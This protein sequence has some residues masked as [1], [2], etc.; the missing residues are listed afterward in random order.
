MHVATSTIERLL[1]YVMNTPADGFRSATSVQTLINIIDKN[2]AHLA[3][4]KETALMNSESPVV[5][6]KS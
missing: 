3:K 2:K 6:G 4:K 5:N 1:D